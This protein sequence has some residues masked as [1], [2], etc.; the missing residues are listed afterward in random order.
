M[1]RGGA[2]HYRTAVLTALYLWQFY[3]GDAMLVRVGP[4]S[5][6]PLSVS[7]TN[8]CSIDMYGWNNVFFG[9]GDSIDQSYTVF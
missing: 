7:V 9:M 1:F 5:Y 2:Y 3:P 4:T 8:R 6:G